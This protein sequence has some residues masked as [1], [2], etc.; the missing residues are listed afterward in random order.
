[1][2]ENHRLT[3]RTAVQEAIGEIFGLDASNYEQIE[4]LREDLR[5]QRKLRKAADHGF[6]V[7]VGTASVA[8]FG[9]IILGIQSRFGLFMDIPP[10]RSMK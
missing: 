2:D 1:M 3:I 7:M 8:L 5:F 10:P 6:L 4:A 9:I